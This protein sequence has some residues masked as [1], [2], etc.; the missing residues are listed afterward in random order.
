MNNK[1]NSSEYIPN[2]IKIKVI[3]V[4]GSGCNTINRMSISKIKWIDLIILNTD[5]QDIEKV[6]ADKKIQIG[7]EATKGFGTGMDIEVGKK[8]AEETKNEIKKAIEDTDLIF[9]AGGFGGGTATGALPVVAEIAKDLKILT[10]AVITLPFSF[11]GSYR[12]KIAEKGL[13]NLKGNVDSLILIE[14]DKLL[15]VL[16][17][18]IT[19]NNAFQECDNILMQA[20]ESISSLITVP[21][22]VNIDFADIKALVKDAGT[23]LFGIGCGSGNNRA[24]EAALKAIQ[25]PLLDNS[26][27]NAKGII[28]NVSGNK[29]DVQLSEINKIAEIITQETEPNA[30]IIFGT[31]YDSTLKKGEIKV[32]IIA[33]GF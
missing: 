1:K 16:D 13:E 14:N 15:E 8:S 29:G 2:K 7:I 20:V 19:I 5:I 11:E 25:F 3:G 28:F 21:G 27:E 18:K 32:T 23:S 9:L 17:S 31:S 26:L 12:R 30:N 24:E 10:I 33:T 22:I 6:Q 4:G